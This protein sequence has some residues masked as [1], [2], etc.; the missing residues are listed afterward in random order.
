MSTPPLQPPLG[1]VDDPVEDLWRQFSSRLRAF[2]M[3]RVD[4]PADVDD[5]LQEV[6]VKIARR[7]STLRDPDRLTTWVFR[8]ANNAII[9]HYR[10][11][12]RRRELPVDDLPTI[13]VSSPQEDAI[14]DPARV[15]EQLGSCIQPL[16]DHLP[17]RYR[18]ALELVE[19]EGMAQTEA[20]KK[21]GLSVSGMKSRVQRGR[22]KVFEQLNDWCA[23]SIDARG[24][25][26]ECVPTAGGECG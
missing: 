4:N 17:E 24:G 7:T 14:D 3:T 11:A 13:S 16:L 18:E 9:D 26:V 25:P 22:A 20:A 8:I 2:I 1:R 12:P 23:V 15:R 6:F 10:A 19:L 5:I 21:L